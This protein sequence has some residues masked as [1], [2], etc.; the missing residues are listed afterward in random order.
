[1]GLGLF[2]KLNGYCPQL[3]PINVSCPQLMCPQLI[4]VAVMLSISATAAA[5]D[6]RPNIVLVLADDVG[7]SDLG[8]YG[9]EIATPNIDA[10]AA[11]GVKFSNFHA[12]PICA[13]SRAMLMSGVDSHFAGIASLPETTPPEHA[14]HRAYQGRLAD[15]VVT[16]ASRLQATG[17]HTYMAGKWH[18]GHG[19]GDLPSAHGFERTF[20][21]DATGADNW[22]QRPY[23]PI[24]DKADWF[25]DGEP[26]TLPDDFYSSEFLIDQTIEFINADRADSQPFFAYVAFQA[27]HIP[28]QAPQEFRDRYLGVYDDGWEQL[29]QSRYRGAIEQGILPEPITLEAPIAGLRPSVEISLEDR[30]MM[31][32]S[33]EVYAGML[34]AMDYHFGRLVAD[35]KDSGLYENTVFIILSDNG[36]EPSDPLSMPLFHLWLDW[37]GYDPEYDTLGE[38]GSF[39]NIG[40]EF[41]TAASAP[42]SYFKFYAGEGGLRVPLILAGPGI[43]AAQVSDSFSFITDIAPTILEIGGTPEVTEWEGSTIQPIE[44]RSLVPTLTDPADGVHGPNEDIALEAAGNAALFRGDL[45]L[46][47]VV[48]PYGDNAWHLYDIRNDPGE[49]HD[50]KDELDDEF[51]NM[52]AAYHAYEARV[53]VL[54]VPEG[55]TQQRQLI[56]NLF[57]RL[58]TEYGPGLRNWAIAWGAFAALMGVLY[59]RHRRRRDAY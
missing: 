17:Y 2:G 59:W 25:Q 36:P 19:D 23:L 28:I 32:R 7:F 30:K 3:M 40:P 29:R 54:P 13:P 45:K 49:V 57:A 56:V 37:I 51:R 8:S 55:Y 44:G 14:E 11:M 42:L 58:R 21:L 1:M 53:G 9:S 47:R 12:S 41:A 46:V 35:L 39:T 43:A 16:V 33:M 27:V 20:A 15:D 34:E 10:L 6:L 50:L 18:L 5:Q 31:A 22:D 48:P 4:L 26:V 24:Y 38:Q 52:L